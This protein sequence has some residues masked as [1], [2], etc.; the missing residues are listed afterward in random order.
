MTA[1]FNVPDSISFGELENL[2]AERA[3]E[4]SSAKQARM[5]LEPTQDNI[6]EAADRALNYAIEICEDPMV[7]KI[8]MLEILNNMV[9]WHTRVGNNLNE[10]DHNDCAVSWLRDAGKLQS[11]MTIL[12]S[13]QI[14]KNDWITE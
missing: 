11:M 5:G 8:M 1:S 4:E 3:A 13:V 14:G 12:L 6:N 9:E 10:D 2:A 7:H